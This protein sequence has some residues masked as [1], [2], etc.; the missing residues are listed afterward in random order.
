MTVCKSTVYMYLC[1]YLT[2]K[3]VSSHWSL[4]KGLPSFK[5]PSRV[6]RRPLGLCRQVPPARRPL[7]TPPIRAMTG[8]TSVHNTL[9]WA[10]ESPAGPERWSVDVPTSAQAEPLSLFTPHFSS[11]SLLAW[12]ASRGQNTLTFKTQLA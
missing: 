5:T 11:D 10:S 12:P 8:Q 2:V 9:S 1:T 3:S 6:A 7:S 4:A